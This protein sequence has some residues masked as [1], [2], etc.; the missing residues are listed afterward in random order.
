M[1]LDCINGVTGERSGELNVNV[2][3]NVRRGKKKM[4]IVVFGRHVFVA[5]F[6][7]IMFGR[8]DYG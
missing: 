7:V 2:G 5:C 6:G 3:V 8:F 1:Y 4:V